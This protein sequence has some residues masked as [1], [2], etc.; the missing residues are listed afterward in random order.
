MTTRFRILHTA[1]PSDRILKDANGN[2]RTF[3]EVMYEFYSWDARIFIVDCLR[4]TFDSPPEA[5]YKEPPDVQEKAREVLILELV[6]RF[7]ESAE[8]LASFG[9]AFATE[10]YK[11]ALTPEEVWKIFAEHET[12]EIV[13]FYTDIQKRGPDYLAN[14]H[15]YPPLDLQDMASRAILF[16]SCGQLAAYLG[17]IADTYLDLREL[18]NSYKHGMKVFF[19]HLT[20]EQ[21]G[22]ENLVVTYV[23]KDATA[24]IVP[25]PH[26]TVKVLYEKCHGIAQ[27]LSAMLHWHK[28]R[29]EVAQS[30]RRSFH[31]PVFG[32]SGEKTR[33]MGPLFFPTLFDMRKDMVSK[34]EKIASQ[35]V[36]EL[37][38]IPRGHVFAVDVDLQEILPCHA[39]ELREVI[40]QAMK[41]RPGAR[42]VFRRLTEDGKVAPY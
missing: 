14:L 42:L 15:G 9:I 41:S 38:R 2:L 26:D 39:P 6:A 10:F 29:M 31:S 21:T 25:F 12:G 20:D 3:P 11:D 18:H 23:D 34:A 1:G 8:D 5:F 35:E 37:S 22:R 4:R 24:K 28:L 7:C 16:R 19:G 13:N 30:G 36:E 40:R 27:L 33:R 32:K 17:S